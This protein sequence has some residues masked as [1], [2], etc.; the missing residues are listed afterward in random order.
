MCGITRPGLSTFWENALA[1]SM[2]GRRTP[3]SRLEALLSCSPNGQTNQVHDAITVYATNLF[4][5]VGKKV[6]SRRHDG[7]DQWP[8]VTLTLE[9]A[10]VDWLQTSIDALGTLPL[11]TLTTWTGG[12]YADA[13]SVILRLMAF[14]HVY[15]L[16]I[17]HRQP[18]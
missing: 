17:S 13:I 2:R 1:L 9:R 18:F 10:G 5:V 11:R 6:A 12:S 8:A 7:G 4:D 14:A 3:F 16:I 15:S